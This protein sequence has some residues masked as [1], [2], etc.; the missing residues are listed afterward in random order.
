[1]GKNVGSCLGDLFSVNWM[2]DSDAKDL[3]QETLAE[4]FSVIKEK[5]SKSQVMQWSDTSFTSDVVSDFL[6]N[7]GDEQAAAN[8]DSSASA[9]SVRQLELRQAYDAYVNAA[10]SAERLQA[11]EDLQ[12][13]L[14]DQ[15]NAE[16]AYEKFLSILYPGD[17]AKQAEART[18]KA[19]PDNYACEMGARENFVAYGAFDAS[20]GFAMQFHKYIV[21]VCA[22]NSHN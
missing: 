16:A 20:S 6:G 9:W 12:A 1:M 11:G 3:T 4:Q 13:M 5:T 14:Q 10:T 17:E 21:N 7:A 8:G 2:E 18:G 22:D 15:L 19:S